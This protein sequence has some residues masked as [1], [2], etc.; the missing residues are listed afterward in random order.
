MPFT[1][2]LLAKVLASKRDSRDVLSITAVYGSALQLLLRYDLQKS[3]G[4]TD[5]DTE[6]SLRE[7]LCTMGFWNHLSGAIAQPWSSFSF[8]GAGVAAVQAS[9]LSVLPSSAALAPF[10]HL[11]FQEYVSA[12]FL[13]CL[14][15]GSITELGA[16]LQACAGD[17]WWSQVLLM[18]FE[19]LSNDHVLPETPDAEPYATFLD[20]LAT[21]LQRQFPS[22]VWRSKIMSRTATNP[23]ATVT[24]T[25]PGCRAK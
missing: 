14:V 2:T 25:T 9:N 10:I 24:I 4:K 8:L 5:A 3:R 23:T 13:A 18:T 15:S 17:S 21:Q 16:W 20:T 11:S 19:V 7:L 12:K 6:V 22:N 1:L